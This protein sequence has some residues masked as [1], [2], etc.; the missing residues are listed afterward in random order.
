MMIGGIPATQAY[1]FH[2]YCRPIA[3]EILV[4]KIIYSKKKLLR[5]QQHKCL[6]QYYGDEKTID[7]WVP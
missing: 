4:R 6:H 7:N 1:D 2:P 3:K 5:T